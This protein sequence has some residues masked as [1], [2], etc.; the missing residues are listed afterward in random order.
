M[1]FRGD[2]FGDFFCGDGGFFGDGD[3]VAAHDSGSRKSLRVA[4]SRSLNVV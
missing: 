3:F 1:T 4:L 2:F